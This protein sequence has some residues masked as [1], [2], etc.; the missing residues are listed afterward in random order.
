[1]PEKTYDHKQIELKWFERWEN[2]PGLYKAEENSPK[3]KYYLLEMLPYPSGTLH[4]GHV[5]NYTIGDA[6]ARYKWMRGFN[7]LH[8]MGWDSFGLPAENAALKR[9]LHPRDW[10]RAN[11]AEMQK[12]HRRFAFSYDWDRELSTCE[13]DYYHWNQW[14]FLKMYE[15]GLAYRKHSRVN[16]CPECA[17]VLA[18]EQVVE[19]CCWRHENTPVEQRE[20]E[21]WF[22][23]ITAYADE[24]LDALAGFEGRWPERVIAM[25]RNWIGRSDG[26]EI[27]FRLEGTG[28]PIRVFT[29]RVDTI[30]GATCVILA[31]E[32]P[33]TARLIP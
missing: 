1:M 11:I 33:L 25:Q 18:N 31:P 2:A 19:G 8:P 16:W 22:F 29:T 3:P 17:T 10:T 23:K 24:L 26:A 32:H 12:T 30:Y 20:L 9:G 21:Q 5:R 15:R 28:E 4:M 7:V 27:D 13:P 6:L 14:L